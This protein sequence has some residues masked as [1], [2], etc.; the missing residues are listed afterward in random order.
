[1][2]TIMQ[3][4]E[5]I[6]KAPIGTRAALTIEY[7]DGTEKYFV[8]IGTE[9]DPLQEVEEDVIDAVFDYG[10]LQG[11]PMEEHDDGT[12]HFPYVRRI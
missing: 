10:V 6:R 1:M 8:G 9:T 3:A 2:L 12:K 11:L 4:F 5:A 7:P